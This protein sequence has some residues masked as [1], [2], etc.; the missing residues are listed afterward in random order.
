MSDFGEDFNIKLGSASIDKDD[1]GVKLSRGASQGSTKSN[2]SENNVKTSNYNLSNATHPF[3]CITTIL[4]KIFAI[5]LYHRINIV[6][7]L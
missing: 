2:D 3:A 5:L 6:I 4:F 1:K 7:C